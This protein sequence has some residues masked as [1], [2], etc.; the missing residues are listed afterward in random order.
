MICPAIAIASSTS[1]RKIQSWNEIWNAPSSASPKRATTAPASRKAAI[2]DAVRDEEEL[3]D[4]DQA[5]SERDDRRQVVPADVTDD[6]PDEAGAHA[7]LRD[8]GPPGGALD[9]PVEAVDEEQLE[10]D[11]EEVAEDDQDERRAQLRDAAQVPLAAEREEERRDA[12]RDDAEVRRRL[13]GRLPLDA[14]ERGDRPREERDRHGEHDAD[15]ERE[16]QRLRPE[17]PGD[18]V[19]ARAGRARDLRGRPV[20]QEVERREDAER[21]R[22]GAE[23]RELRRVRDGRRSRCRRGCTAAR[24]R[25]RPA[26]GARA[27]GSRRRTAT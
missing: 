9:P 13:V 27:G 26:P 21:R 24:P 23:R 25:A 5:A 17:L 22:G 2:S 12:D 7:R 11:V 20:L 19:L 16:P 1:A 4:R 6:E 3:P 18:G 10:D 14:D 8:R 15:A